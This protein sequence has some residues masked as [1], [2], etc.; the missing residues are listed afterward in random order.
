MLQSKAL[1]DIHGQLTCSAHLGAGFHSSPGL[2]H[3][4]ISVCVCPEVRSSSRRTGIGYAS[5]VACYNYAPLTA[6]CVNSLQVAV[7]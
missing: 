5:E 4:T 7:N 3:L 2:T 6:Q 1:S